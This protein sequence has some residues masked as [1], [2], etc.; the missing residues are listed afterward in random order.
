MSKYHDN[1]TA[2]SDPGGLRLSIDLLRQIEPAFGELLGPALD[3]SRDAAELVERLDEHLRLGDTRAACCVSV[4]PLLVAAYSD[5]LDCVALLSFPGWLA[6][7]FGLLPGFRLLTVNTYMDEANLAP[8]LVAG[9]RQL[10]RYTN[11]YPVIADFVSE[12]TERIDQRKAT[13]SEEEWRRCDELGEDYVRDSPG[14]WR[15]GSPLYSWSSD[16]GA[17]Q[18]LRVGA[19][20]PV[21]SFPT[22]TSERLAH[23]ITCLLLLPLYVGLFAVLFPVEL[24]RG[25]WIG[26]AVLLLLQEIALAMVVYASLALIWCLFMPEWLRR[27]AASVRT[28]M[29][30][31]FLIFVVA[32]TL[33]F[34]AIAIR[35]IVE[36]PA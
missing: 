36:G 12:D 20:E 15:N 25:Q 4:E 16:D 35:R 30:R 27:V 26:I 6:D 21:P 18:D 3:R 2:A 14:Q 28:K 24:P 11:F 1:R 23:G 29:M 5:E 33:L 34:A 22:T 31:S 32:G 9:P 8:D 7:R 13:I 19:A 17:E 10:G